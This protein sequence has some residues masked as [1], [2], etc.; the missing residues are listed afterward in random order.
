MVDSAITRKSRVAS[1]MRGQQ[2]TLARRSMIPVVEW[3]RDGQ[4]S[5]RGQM[6]IFRQYLNVVND[7]RVICIENQIVM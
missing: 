6:P 3:F 4:C 7:D 2:P 1:T 5:V